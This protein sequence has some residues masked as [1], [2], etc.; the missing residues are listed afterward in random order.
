MQ[1]QRQQELA[2]Y[3]RQQSLEPLQSQTVHTGAGAPDQ[4]VKFSPVQG[5][6]KALQAMQGGDMQS[7]VDADRLAMAR[8][9]KAGRDAEVAK[10]S[11]MMYGKPAQPGTPIASPDNPQGAIYTDDQTAVPASDQQGYSTLGTPATPPA[12]QREMAAALMSSSQP[13]FQKQGLAHMFQKPEG[14]SLKAGEVRF[15]GNNQQIASAPEKSQFESSSPLE[16]EYAYAVQQGYKGSVLD[17][18][19]AKSGATHITNNNPPAVT[20]VTIQDPKDPNKTQI[21]DGRTGKVIGAGPKMTEA[22]SKEYKRA[23]G[24]SGLGA[25]IQEADDILSGKDGNP[26]PTAS[27]IGSLI[28]TGSAVFGVTP[29]GA[30]QADKLRSIGGAMVAKMPRMEGPQSD[31]DVQLYKEMAGRIGDST[32]PIDRRRAA[33]ETVKEL[34]SKYEHLNPPPTAAPSAGAQQPQPAG[35]GFKIIGVR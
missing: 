21:V 35:G 13:D 11:G 1:I 15:D 8:Q 7:G 29:E 6:V 17:W 26:L 30:K 2:N 9:L 24:M 20:A 34:W 3:L 32:I 23:F 31:K 10:I 5:L 19:K 18:M 14:Y 27:G 16:K 25:A 28:D 4:V 33:L 22:G 12:S